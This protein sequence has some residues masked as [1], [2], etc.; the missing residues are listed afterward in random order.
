LTDSQ[1][2]PKTKYGLYSTSQVLHPLI[3]V[4]NSKEEKRKKKFKILNKGKL[5][6]KPKTEQGLNCET[7]DRY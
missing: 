4:F 2:S 1:R 3:F 6:Q 7:F 5:D